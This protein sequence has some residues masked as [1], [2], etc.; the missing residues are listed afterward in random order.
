MLKNNQPKPRL[1]FSRSIPENADSNSRQSVS[2]AGYSGICVSL[3]VS[4]EV[5]NWPM[6]IIM[7][8]DSRS[9]TLLPTRDTSERMKA[10][11]SVRFASEI[12]EINS[13]SNSSEV[14]RLFFALGNLLCLDFKQL[15][16]RTRH[17]SSPGS[18][19]RTRE[20]I[21]RTIRAVF[22]ARSTYLP[23]QKTL[24][25]TLLGTSGDPRRNA[26]GWLRGCSR[27]KVSTGLSH[28]THAS[29]L[30]PPRC[31]DT[32]EP[33]ASETRTSPPVIA[34]Q[35]LPVLSTY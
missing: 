23:N 1:I 26:T 15:C 31:I 14:G 35:P 29:L 7:A 21:D 32:T 24:S 13:R 33:S 34:V 30:C 19:L 18:A 28:R 5:R 11:L 9:R 27:L 22:S 4:S 10:K 6:R 8:A 25:A 17:P 20:I 3:S 16:K 2:V 12:T